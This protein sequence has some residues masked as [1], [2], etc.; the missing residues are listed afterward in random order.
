M[1]CFG[2][3]P[4][5]YQNPNR[6]HSFI[7][8]LTFTSTDTFS[9]GIHAGIVRP[10][11][12]DCVLEVTDRSW[13]GSAECD[14]YY[15]F[16]ERKLALALH[17]SIYALVPYDTSKE[18]K[19]GATQT[20]CEPTI[21]ELAEFMRAFL[22]QHRIEDVYLV[23]GGCD[24][25]MT[26]DELGLGTPTEDFFTMKIMEWAT[27]TLPIS[28]KLALI[29]LDLDTAHGIQRKDLN[30]RLKRLHPLWTWNLSLQEPSVAQYRDI[31]YRCEP[32]NSIVHS[33][34]MGA[35]EGLNDYVVPQ[36]LA[37]RLRKTLVP[38]THRLRTMFCYSLEEVVKDC[39]FWSAIETHL[40]CDQVDRVICDLHERFY[41]TKLMGSLV[42]LSLARLCWDYLGQV[43]F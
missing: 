16:P 15:Y 36:T 39:L 9:K 14:A 19:E 42:P 3:L 34:V 29:G 31:F 24:S 21:Q 8:N 7:F 2:C 11:F 38:I 12:K 10:L 17:R 20:F 33:M 1:D 6:E 30:K 23:D 35:L 32:Q 43:L 28:P 5:F 41:V 25:L 4:L 22:L 18:E 27:S 37:K 13:K 40:T 26:G